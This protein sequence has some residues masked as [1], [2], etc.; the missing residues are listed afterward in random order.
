VNETKSLFFVEPFDIPNLSRRRRTCVCVA[1]H[2]DTSCNGTFFIPLLY[3]RK[4]EYFH[5]TKNSVYSFDDGTH[6][7]SQYL[8]DWVLEQVEQGMGRNGRNRSTH[9]HASYPGNYRG[10]HE[11]ASYPARH[12]S[13]HEHASYEQ[14]NIHVYTQRLSKAV[15]YGN[16]V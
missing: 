12:R 14:S 16:N 3:P 9:H 10:T 1:G 11:H 7:W 4:D 6:Y 13:T 15:T 8:S 2:P 5:Q